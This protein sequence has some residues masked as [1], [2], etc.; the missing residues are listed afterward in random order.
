MKRKQIKKLNMKKN[1]TKIVNEF[2]TKHSEGFT[3]NEMKGLLKKEFPSVTMK[4][5]SKK[6][7]VHTGMIKNGDFLTYHSDVELGIRCC[8]ENRNQTIY[9]W[10]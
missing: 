9:E 8:L 4:E 6:L 5:F 1:I 2:K 3:S 10:D 7:G